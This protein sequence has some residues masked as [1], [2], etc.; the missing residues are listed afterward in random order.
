MTLLTQPKQLIHS[1]MPH[2]RLDHSSIY[3][4]PYRT[5]LAVCYNLL[6]L[7]EIEIQAID[8]SVIIAL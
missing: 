7:S 2:N 1:N 6:L 8:E 4:H 3:C 5:V